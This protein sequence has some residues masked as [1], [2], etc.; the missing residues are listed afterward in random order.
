ML[1]IALV[2]FGGTMAS[3]QSLKVVT[4]IKP[5]H[6]LASAVMEGVG[7]P[8]LLIRGAVSPH[9]FNLRPSDARHISEADLIFVIGEGIESSLVRHIDSITIDASVVHLAEI[10]DLPLLDFRTE[11]DF[12]GHDEHG[13]DEH[14]HDEHGHDEHG[15]DHG[16]FDPHVWTDPAIAQ[17]LVGAMAGNLAE[18]DPANA[19]RYAENAE[20]LIDRLRELDAEIATATKPVVG[21]PYIVFHDA[22]Q[23][24]ETRYG[25]NSVDTILLSP[26]QMPSANRLQAVRQRIQETGAVCV[27]REPQFNDNIVNVIVEGT[28]V[29][30]GIM[31]P[32]GAD[33][34]DGPDLYFM[35]IR[36]MASSLRE[37][38]DG[39]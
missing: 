7:A 19:E 8:V 26:E 3:A 34:E 9:S 31:D 25:L 17:I 5:V 18:M 33:L 29:R 32:L 11:H 27:F 39:S 20:R 37:C 30:T 12:G 6:S 1:A 10:P 14:G 38:L 4:S 16:D 28:A 15:H 24:F 13:H 23:Y 2:S 22:Y 35:L 21:K 36:N